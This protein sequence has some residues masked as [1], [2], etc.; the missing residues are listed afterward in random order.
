MRWQE[1]THLFDGYNAVVVYED[2]SLKVRHFEGR[3]ICP[4]RLGI[5]TLR[6]QPNIIQHIPPY[7]HVIEI[8][9]EK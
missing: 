7:A 9:K 1:V 2:M 3:I 8:K 4:I 5:A 6:T